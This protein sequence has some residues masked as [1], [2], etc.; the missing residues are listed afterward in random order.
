VSDG[1]KDNATKPH[2]RP[3][4]QLRFTGDLSDVD[5]RPAM[6]LGWDLLDK[7]PGIKYG[8]L[9]DQQPRR[10]DPSY[11]DQLYSLEVGPQ[12]VAEANGIVICRPWVKPSAFARGAG[13]LVAIGRAG[14]GYDKIDVAACTAN[15]VV[16]FNSPYGLTH[17]TAV[18]ALFFILGLSKRFPLQERIVREYRWDLQKDA[19]GDDLAGGT[20]G[21][22]GLGHSGLELARLIAP[23]GMR[24]IAFSPHA[25]PAKARELGVALVGSLD[26][27]LGESDYVSLHCRLTERTCQMIGPREL[28]LMKPGAYFVNVARG[29]LVDEPALVEALRERRIAGAGLDVFETEPLPLDNPLLKLDNVILTPHWLA[30]TRQAGRATIVPI[31]EG[32][33]R[34]ARGQLPD[35]ILNPSVL[36]RPGFQTKLARYRTA[37]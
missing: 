11:Q 7:E 31:I 22:V 36:E 32:M 17:S 12:H 19:I 18:A 28:G 8:F 6:D 16:V 35:N 25:D 37:E 9:T 4:F 23:F 5:G 27:L 10:D 21:I 24:L 1:G 14:I 13:Q 20:L 15:D 30:S 33:L 34:V 29:E 2:A 3:V 26:T